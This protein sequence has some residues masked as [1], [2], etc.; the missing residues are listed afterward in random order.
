MIE[1]RARNG[2]NQAD[3]WTHLCPCCGRRRCRSGSLALSDH[4]SLAPRPPPPAS[5]P[6]ELHHHYSYWPHGGA[7]YKLQ[8]VQAD[9]GQARRPL[10]AFG[11]LA[12]PR[13]SKPEP[14]HVQKRRLQIGP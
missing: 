5:R 9:Q 14:V 7:S 6:G 11:K 2:F 4:F 10:I 1:R 8:V 13:L 3:Y 12:R